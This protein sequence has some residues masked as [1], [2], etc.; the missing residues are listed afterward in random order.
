[1]DCVAKPLADISSGMQS[2][3]EELVAKVKAAARARPRARSTAR[4]R[5]FSSSVL[6]KT[7]GRRPSSRSRSTC[8]AIASASGEV[9]APLAPSHSSPRSRCFRSACSLRPDGSPRLRP[10]RSHWLMR[11]LYV[12]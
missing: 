10:S 7:T 8:T 11:R 3:G 12:E 6:A 5:I 2:L 1:M 9:R 4:K